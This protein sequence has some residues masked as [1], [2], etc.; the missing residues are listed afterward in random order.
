MAC[1]AV[2]KK[3]IE[4]PYWYTIQ[5]SGDEQEAVKKLGEHSSVNWHSSYIS[6]KLSLPDWLIHNQQPFEWINEVLLLVRKVL[7]KIWTRIAKQFHCESGQHGESTGD[8]R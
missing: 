6:V 8:K 1:T 2:F 5:Q 4:K 3:Q 7:I